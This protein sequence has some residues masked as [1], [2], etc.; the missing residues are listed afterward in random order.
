MQKLQNF[1]FRN[2]FLHIS[3]QVAETLQKSNIND[4]AYLGFWRHNG[5]KKA[6]KS[7]VTLQKTKLYC[8]KSGKANKDIKTVHDDTS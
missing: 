7:K 1:D 8:L 5:G 4:V 6:W 3:E 2:Q